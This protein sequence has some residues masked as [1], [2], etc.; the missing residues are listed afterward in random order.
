MCKQEC[1]QDLHSNRYSCFLFGLEY[2]LSWFASQR[3]QR[4]ASARNAEAKIK[5]WTSLA[6]S[7]MVDFS[8]CWGVF[9]LFSFLSHAERE[10]CKGLVNIKEFMWCVG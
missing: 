1:S 10:L 5:L 7:K 3:W 4:C 8:G 9:Y 2:S 6:K